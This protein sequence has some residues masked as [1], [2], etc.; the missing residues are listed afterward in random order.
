MQ[1]TKG[2]IGTPQ[3][4]VDGRA[5]V[6]GQAKYAAEFDTPDLTY[7]IVIS[8]SI[9]K[10]RIASIDAAAALAVPG[11]SE[12]VHARESSADGVARPQLPRRGRASRLAVPAALRR[13]GQV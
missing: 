1:H 3:N 10:G 13:R 4:R 11:V 7:G 12:R 2:L 8:S 9:A 6:T 5:K